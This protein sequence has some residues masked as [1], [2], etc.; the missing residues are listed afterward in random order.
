MEI[1]NK[2][3]TRTT[4]FE[5]QLVQNHKSYGNK[6]FK[7]RHDEYF[8]NEKQERYKTPFLR[9]RDHHRWN[10]AKLTKAQKRQEVE[11]LEQRRN[12]KKKTILNYIEAYEDDRVQL[13]GSDVVGVLND[14]QAESQKKFDSGI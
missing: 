3:E 10:V 4:R 6:I 14:M 2:Q 8:D 13:R 7:K 12:R 9:L 11:W 1:F 5:K